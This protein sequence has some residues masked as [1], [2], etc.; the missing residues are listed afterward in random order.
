MDWSVSINFNGNLV[1]NEYCEITYF[2]SLFKNNSDSVTIVYGFDDDWKYT[3]SKEMIKTDNGF[4]TRIKML[5][6]KSFNFCFR[7]SNYEWDNNNS[8]NYTSPITKEKTST[9]AEQTTNT[10]TEDNNVIDVN[11]DENN[12]INKNDNVETN[13]NNIE[14]IVTE[15]KMVTEETTAI[16]EENIVAEPDSFDVDVEK[17]EPLNMEETLVNSIEEINLNVDIENIF[18][19]IY[20]SPEEPVLENIENIST[21]TNDSLEQKFNMNSLIDEILSPITGSTVFEGEKNNELINEIETAPEIIEDNT[22]IQLANSETDIEDDT[23]IDNLIDGLITDLYNN[24]DN[25]SND[26]IIEIQEEIPEE[27]EEVSEIVVEPAIIKK[28]TKIPD[29]VVLEDDSEETTNNEN[30]KEDSLLENIT[31]PVDTKVSE[32]ESVQNVENTSLAVSNRTLSKFYMIK[33][34]IKL[35]LMKIFRFLPKGSS[36]EDM[37]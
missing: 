2:G 15:E 26:N 29:F 7:N 23:K 1:V 5:D 12:S 34:K 14:N 17:N 31:P 30:V 19:D 13:N 37:N 11:T 22:N 32:P 21:D 10:S 35:A 24:I 4:V 8:Q 18:E 36:S 3:D 27:N 25:N 28:A 16:T 9:E 33:K 20:V 6:F